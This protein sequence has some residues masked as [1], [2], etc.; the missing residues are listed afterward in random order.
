MTESN[1][2]L[3]IGLGV[4]AALLFIVVIL[5]IVYI[6]C[7]IHIVHCYSRMSY[8]CCALL[9]QNVTYMLCFAFPAQHVY[10]ILEKQS[11][12]SVSHSGKAIHNISMTFWKSNTQHVYDILEKQSTTSVSHSG[13][14]I[15]NF[16]N[17]TYMLCFAFPE[18]HIHVVYCF[19]KMSNS[20]CALL[21]QNVIYMLCI[22][23]P[24]CHIHVVYCF[25]R[26]SC[27]T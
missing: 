5:L 1:D 9:F 4:T 14:A 6:E 18:C 17:V 22:A 16:Q 11:T 13:K 19:S 7:H 25:S 23:L 20:Y 8:I 10:D 12:T 21:F 3:A 15:H 26:M 2:I 24:E 27:N